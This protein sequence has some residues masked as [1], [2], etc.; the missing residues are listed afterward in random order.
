LLL[1][2]AGAFALT[3]KWGRYLAM[4]VTGA[5]FFQRFVLKDDDP[6]KTWSHNFN[7]ALNAFGRTGVAKGVK[8]GTGYRSANDVA[9]PA[10]RAEVVVKFLD[11]TNRLNM[12]SQA[13]GLAIML[14]MP[15]DV[16]ARNFQSTGPGTFRLELGAV[17]TV[18]DTIRRMDPKMRR[19]FDEFF[20]VASNRVMASEAM[21]Y[22]FYRKAAQDPQNARDYELVERVLDRLPSGSLSL[23]WKVDGRPEGGASHARL[24]HAESQYLPQNGPSVQG[25][26]GVPNAHRTPNDPA[27]DADIRRAGAAYVRLVERGRAMSVGEGTTLRSFMNSTYDF[28][29]ITARRAAR[30]YTRNVAGSVYDGATGSPEDDVSPAFD[31]DVAGAASDHESGEASD[32]RSG[33]AWEDASG[34]AKDDASGS[35]KEDASG[36]ARDDA[37]KGPND[38]SAHGPRDDSAGGAYDEAPGSARDDASGRASDGRF[39]GPEGK[40][41][42]SAADGRPRGPL[43]NRFS[44]PRGSRSGAPSDRHAG[45]PSGDASG[46]AERDPAS[47]ADDERSGAPD[48][49]EGG[50]ANDGIR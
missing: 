9:D 42:G 28:K 4:G 41:S 24:P 22:V 47:G 25:T 13:Q 3:N 35:A 43:D 46:S 23:P 30:S 50:T 37:A 11:R 26:E 33:E 8:E 18:D 40:R 36:S 10:K 34:T 2:A 7:E 39:R 32:D 31:D 49:R 1:L 17:G 5:Y 48:D 45:S 6:T 38:G 44:A 20:N 12:E 19:A 29:T 27:F 16:L 21:S 15:M 14:E